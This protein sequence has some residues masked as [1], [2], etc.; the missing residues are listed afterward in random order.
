[1]YIYSDDFQITTD[2]SIF[3]F[4]AEHV[5]QGPI[6][7]SVFPNVYN[8]DNTTDVYCYINFFRAPNSLVIKREFQKILDSF[9]Y[10]GGLLGSFL[11]ILI[12][13]VFYNEGSFELNFASALYLPEDGSPTT[14]RKY[15]LFYY[16]LQGIYMTFR[17]IGI[18][19]DWK[20]T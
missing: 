7:N 8:L 2:E 18:R 4:T 13:I 19:L 10:V 15:N 16:I 20:C 5:D 6:V 9:A 11:L 17:I 3:P 14:F 1:M 12:I